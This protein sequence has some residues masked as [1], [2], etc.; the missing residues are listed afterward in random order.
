MRLS[1]PS[2]PSSSIKSSVSQRPS[3]DDDSDS[4]INDQNEFEDSASGKY[5]RLSSRSAGP[6]RLEN[7]ATASSSST[8][9][10]T[11]TSASLKPTSNE[12][13][14]NSKTFSTVSA[15]IIGPSGSGRTTPPGPKP[16]LS[17]QVSVSTPDLR[18]Q[19][20]DKQAAK[21]TP[22]D[23]SDDEGVFEGADT[24]DTL[25]ASENEASPTA[26]YAS[27]KSKHE[28]DHT[29]RKGVPKQKSLDSD[30]SNN[31]KKANIKKF[32]KEG[33]K[34]ETVLKNKR[35]WFFQK[36]N[37][38]EDGLSDPEQVGCVTEIEPSSN[39]STKS[40]PNPDLNRKVT[41]K[42][43]K[44]QDFKASKQKKAPPKLKI[45]VDNSPNCRKCKLKFGFRS[46]K[47]HC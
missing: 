3:P 1:C 39:P 38:E 30:K 40:S 45:K 28:S 36:K 33:E 11:K 24:S 13:K 9:C 18:S 32:Q 41:D 27:N 17:H 21:T 8:T 46:A 42:E 26:A 15:M 19:H 5:T 43:I 14:S 20:T 37:Y 31:I 25:S 7:K 34:D 16:V 4:D 23:S 35:T 2:S 6:T 29:R 22:V 47:N 44:L 12:K 10:S